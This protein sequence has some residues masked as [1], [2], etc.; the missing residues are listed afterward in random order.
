M[1]SRGLKYKNYDIMTLKMISCLTEENN[2]SALIRGV[3][4]FLMDIMYSKKDK[5]KEMI[6]HRG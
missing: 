5:N 3:K 1:Y 6:H 2:Q 4:L